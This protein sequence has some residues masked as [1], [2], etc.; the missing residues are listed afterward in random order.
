MYDKRA[1]RIVKSCAVVMLTLC[2]AR[3]E[4][5]K[6]CASSMTTMWLPRKW[7]VSGLRVDADASQG[8]ILFQR[9]AECFASR[10]LHEH[11]VRE[12]DYFGRSDGF[13]RA[14][15]RARVHISTE[16]FDILDVAD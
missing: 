6:L 12:R 5:I 4:S 10:L 16:I 13:A 7:R 9:N 15:V 11:V 2:K 3:T 8:D 14:I 1:C